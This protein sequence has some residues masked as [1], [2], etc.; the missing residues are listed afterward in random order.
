MTQSD[1]RRPR[2]VC[3]VGLLLLYVALGAAACSGGPAVSS[4]D[5][6]AGKSGPLLFVSNEIDGTVS[7][8]D[9]VS[10]AVVQTI[11]VGKRPRGIRAS[12]DGQKVYVA[13]SGSP[14]GGPG[15]DESTL[16]PPERRHDGVGVI[17]VNRGRLERILPSGT[18]PEQFALS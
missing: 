9:T 12:A 14:I 1:D 8:I 13:L 3:P 10:R 4:S 5:S 11:Q 17:D 15:V 2:A 16:P 18:D 7:A 6:A